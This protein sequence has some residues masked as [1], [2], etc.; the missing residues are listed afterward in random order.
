MKKSFFSRFTKVK[1]GEKTVDK[2]LATP[3]DIKKKLE[4]YE[5]KEGRA[6]F[7]SAGVY[8]VSEVDGEQEKAPANQAPVADDTQ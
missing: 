3:D 4:H 1:A 8:F 5:C 7:G 2:L 6:R